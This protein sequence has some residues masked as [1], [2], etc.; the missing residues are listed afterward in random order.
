[1]ADVAPEAVGGLVSLYGEAS[2]CWKGTAAEA[3]ACG[4]ACT[5]TL[6]GRPECASTTQEAHL[7]ALCTGQTGARL[8]LDADLRMSARTGGTLVLSPLPAGSTRY[9][10]A[11]ALEVWP[12]VT[13]VASTSGVRGST[14]GPFAVSGGAF[15]VDGRSVRVE[16]LTVEDLRSKGKSFCSS[17]SFEVSSPLQTT[18][19]SSCVYLA[20]ADGTAVPAMD[21]AQ[22][23]ACD[24]P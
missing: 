10:R 14:A 16:R 4:K 22:I 17:L 24:V 8:V 18:L 11:R 1:M 9:E 2:N 20:V 3:E 5:K 21:E 6:A 19:G 13:L 23:R 15:G 12:E 7:L